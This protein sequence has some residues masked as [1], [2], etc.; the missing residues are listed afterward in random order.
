M[1]TFTPPVE[2]GPASI[3]GDQHPLWPHF[4]NYDVGVTVWRDQNGNYHQSQFPYQGG[5]VNRHF[6]HDQVTTDVDDDVESLANAVEV[7]MG[8]GVYPIT[9]QQADDLTAAG[10]GAN[11]TP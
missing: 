11:I 8:G 9:Q 3:G 2:V 4:G 1:P 10:Y 6:N 7:Y 5:Y